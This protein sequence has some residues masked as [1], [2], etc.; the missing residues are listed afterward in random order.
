M[1]FTRLLHVVVAIAGTAA[2]LIAGPDSRVFMQQKTTPKTTATVNATAAPVPTPTP[3]VA[4][5][6]TCTNRTCCKQASQSRS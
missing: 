5:A 2:F 4:V 3:I 1:K 6:A